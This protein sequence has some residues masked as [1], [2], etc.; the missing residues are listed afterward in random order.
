MSAHRVKVGRCPTHGRVTGGD[1]DTQY[2]Q[3]PTCG[4]CGAGLETAGM[5]EVEEV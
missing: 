5:T 1:V 3:Y 2:P 4:K